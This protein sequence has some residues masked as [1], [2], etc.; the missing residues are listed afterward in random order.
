MPFYPPLFY[1][2]IPGVVVFPFLCFFVSIPFL[3]LPKGKEWGQ[4]F[5]FLSLVTPVTSDL[6]RTAYGTAYGV[7]G[8]RHI[9]FVILFYYL[10]SDGGWSG[11]R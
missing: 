11:Q 6:I 2:L 3:S 7:Y 4:V 5:Y 10:D 9:I 1:L 8:V